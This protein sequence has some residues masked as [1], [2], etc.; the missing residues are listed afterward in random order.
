MAQFTLTTAAIQESVMEKWGY[1]ISYKKTLD[2][3]HK[4]VRQ[5]FGDFTQSYTD[6]PCFFLAI[7]QANLG[8]V[9]IWKTCEI[10]MPNIEIFQ[11]VF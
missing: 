8:C 9:V 5:L 2:G 1:E 3:N 4:A 6:L 11:R 7:E 10:N